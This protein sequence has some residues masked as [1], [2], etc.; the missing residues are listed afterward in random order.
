MS[1]DLVKNKFDITTFN[2]DFEK[3]KEQLKLNQQTE[4]EK[5]LNALNTPTNV[6]QLSDMSIHQLLYEWKISLIEFIDDLVN[7]RLQSHILFNGNKLL[8]V[9]LTIVVLVICFYAIHW[10]LFGFNDTVVKDEHN[11]NVSFYLPK[12]KNLSEL[13]HTYMS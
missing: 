8:F 7:L 6:R 11:I 12:K 13:L 9:G 1:I 2:A 10:L 5:K 3:Q 4:D